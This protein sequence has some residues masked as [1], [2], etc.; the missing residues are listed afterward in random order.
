MADPLPKPK[1]KYWTWAEFDAL[2][3]EQQ[4]A[5][6]PHL[7]HRDLIALGFEAQGSSPA[8]RPQEDPASERIPCDATPNERRD[9]IKNF[10]SLS[11]EQQ[12]IVA[13]AMCDAHEDKLITRTCFVRVKGQSSV[14]FFGP[15]RKP[16]QQSK[17]SST[18]TDSIIEANKS[19]ANPAQREHNKEEEEASIK[20][21]PRTF[22]PRTLSDE[23]LIQ[24]EDAKEN[25]KIDPSSKNTSRGSDSSQVGQVLAAI[26]VV[27]ATI[28]MILI[29]G[30]GNLSELIKSSPVLTTLGF[31]A[32]A[33]ILVFAYSGKNPKT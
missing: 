15:D 18:S 5:I 12:V 6:Q 7:T 8:Y 21:L 23:L 31:V 27:A 17:T 30:I 4:L 29:G 11:I 33:A 2:T 19:Q 1:G 22:D 24:K 28:G 13:K 20:T 14:L 3:A 32:V 16:P 25:F 9:F 10:N 26:V